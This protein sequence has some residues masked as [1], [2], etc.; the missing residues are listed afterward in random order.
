M[1]QEPVLIFKKR[2]SLR[3]ISGQV[4]QFILHAIEYENPYY[5]LFGLKSEKMLQMSVSNDDL[6]VELKLW[7]Q[8]KRIWHPAILI[9]PRVEE[10]MMNF[11]KFGHAPSQK[12]L[13]FWILSRSEIDLDFDPQIKF[14]GIKRRDLGE[15][16]H[17]GSSSSG[18]ASSIVNRSGTVTNAS[19]GRR[20]TSAP[21]TKKKSTYPDYSADN[22]SAVLLGKSD[23]IQK[24]KFSR[25][26][27]SCLLYT[28]P[29]PRD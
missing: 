22:V 25:A 19:S 12:D 8:G 5:I 29:S 26:K 11:L 17:K 23:A 24:L 14:G 10:E 4:I 6:A 16:T 13:I 20:P 3:A 18:N 9:P 2:L 21:T 1:E 27:G 28:S 7:L 15:E